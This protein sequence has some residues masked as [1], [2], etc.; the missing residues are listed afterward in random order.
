MTGVAGDSVFGY[1]ILILCA[2]V[3]IVLLV[4]VY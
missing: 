1:T 2:C 4:L 3:D